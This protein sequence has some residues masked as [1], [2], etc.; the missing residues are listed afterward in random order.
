MFQDKDIICFLGDSI[1]ASGLCMA[2]VYQRLRKKY[3]IKC[4][5]CGVSGS[6]A[7]NAAQYLHSNC[8]IYNPDYVAIMFGINDIDCYHYGEKYDD[9]EGRDELL[10]T[11]M[12]THKQS[13]EALVK[14]CIAAG[15]KPILCVPVPYD[16]VS[17]GPTVNCKCQRGLDECEKFL[18]QLAEIYDCPVVDFKREMQPMLGKREII[19]PDRVHP[20]PEGYHVMAQTFLRD[21]G[22][23][24]VC[25]F[26]TPFEKE[27]WNEERFAA[28]QKLHYTDFVEFCAMFWDG[29]VSE[30][31]NEEKKAMAQKLWDACEDK[32]SYHAMAYADYIQK[33]DLRGKLL[34][35]VVRL[36]VF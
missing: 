7:K 21:V 28:E 34:G 2:E 6:T 14:E 10:R 19:R 23:I 25:D 3:K 20:T 17:E 16:Q 31:S 8:L 11:A 24:D 15:A 5:N 33:I 36:T 4:Y 18:R 13:Y 30:K 35:E 12:D 22:E 27:S 1:T 32:N 26:D 29:W 9:M